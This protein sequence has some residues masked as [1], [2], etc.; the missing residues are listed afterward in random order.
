VISELTPIQVP[1]AAASADTTS[2]QVPRRYRQF[3]PVRA[4]DTVTG[5]TGN[6]FG[7]KVTTQLKAALNDDS[8]TGPVTIGSSLGDGLASIC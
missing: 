5:G 1:D 6:A 7:M 3:T 4:N 2:M 8:I